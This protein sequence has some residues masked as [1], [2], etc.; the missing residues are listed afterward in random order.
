MA[1]LSTTAGLVRRLGDPD[2]PVLA[3]AVMVI[4]SLLLF[5]A[6]LVALPSPAE[7]SDGPVIDVST[8]TTTSSLL[9]GP[10][11][12]ILPQPT[13]DAHQARVIVNHR[14]TG[15]EISAQL[16][17]GEGLSV[18]LSDAGPRA[19]AVQVSSTAVHVCG[20]YAGSLILEATHPDVP[21]DLLVLDVRY[22]ECDDAE[23]LAMAPDSVNDVEP[24]WAEE[25]VAPWVPVAPVVPS[26]TPTEPTPTETDPAT[27][28]PSPQATED[29]PTRDPKPSP[30]EP[31]RTPRPD[32]TTSPEPEP[33]GDPTGTSEPSPTSEPTSSPSP[34]SGPTSEPTSDPSPTSTSTEDGGATGGGGA[35]PTP[36][37]TA[38]SGQG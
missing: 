2:R 22:A 8:E 34:T 5:A 24:T 30:D 38:T 10:T 15:V 11:Q 37:T 17:N 27:A 23:A 32:P 18:E 28:S 12:V 14:A 1:P 21:S 33:T 20:H 26:P 13:G 9:D 25:G 7:G 19:T 16:A 29:R 6:V 3:V 31:T 35:S 4:G 36:T